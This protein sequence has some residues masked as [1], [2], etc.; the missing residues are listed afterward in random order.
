MTKVIAVLAA[1][2]V[3]E[4]S[5]VWRSTKLDANDNKQ[6]A[7]GGQL[8]LAAAAAAFKHDPSQVIYVSGGRGYD[9]K[10][11]DKNQPDISAIMKGELQ[12]MGVEESK[13]V[14]E[15]KSNT[16]ADQLVAL[17]RL[18]EDNH[19]EQVAIFSSRYHIPRVE[20]MIRKNMFWSKYLGDK[21][22]ELESAEDYLLENGM[23]EYKKMVDLAYSSDWMGKRMKKEREG[24]RDLLSG[25]YKF[26]K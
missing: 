20:A 21:K 11:K 13:I 18:C 24:I 22:L 10:E 7:P 5:G 2:I 23:D 16:T 17:A 26:K 3:K 9:I 25:E 19:W 6:G 4:K 14:E 8:R 12:N 15:N 1:G